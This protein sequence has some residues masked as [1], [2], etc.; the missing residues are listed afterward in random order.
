MIGCI[1]ATDMAKHASD[2]AQMKLLIDTKD[3]KD[4]E[5][6]HLILNKEN[7]QTFFKSQQFMLET[8]LHACDVS[9]QTR[10]FTTVTKWTYLLFEEFFNQGDLEKTHSLPVSFLCDRETTHIPQMQPGFINGVTLPL[11]APL[12][13]IM[14]SMLEFVDAADENCEKWLAY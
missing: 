3:I 4:G 9:Q 10:P 7:D 8:C 12:S 5:N 6:A 14:P 1:L 11:F 13:Q 2:I